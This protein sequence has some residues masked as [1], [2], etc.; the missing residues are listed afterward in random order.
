MHMRLLLLL[1]YVNYHT[2][3]YIYFLREI[4]QILVSPNQVY[5]YVTFTFIPVL[6]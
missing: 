5:S 3:I 2:Y 1:N 6:R 4:K